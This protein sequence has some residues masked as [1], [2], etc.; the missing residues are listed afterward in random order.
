MCFSTRFGM[1]VRQPSLH[2]GSFGVPGGAKE[3]DR[4]GDLHPDQQT[5]YR[6]QSTVDDVVRH[7]AHVKSKADVGNPPQRGGDERSGQDIAEARFFWTRHAI[8]NRQRYGGQKNGGA[9]EEDAPEILD[10]L[11]L[12]Q[13]VGHPSADGAAEDAEK[14]A[15][16]N[17]AMVM[18]SK[19]TLR[20]CR[21]Q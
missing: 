21:C 2:F 6:G 3:N 20:N 17:G 11:V 14:R 18:S 1:F 9:V 19:R 16:S 7:A 12:T 10:G 13:F 5:D 8:N 15:T 4:G